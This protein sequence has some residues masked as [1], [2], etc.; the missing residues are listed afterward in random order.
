MSSKLFLKCYGVSLA[1]C[2]QIGVTFLLIKYN[3]TDGN[4]VQNICF[5]NKATSHIK[6]VLYHCIFAL[7]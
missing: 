6:A 3:C 2:L 5:K 1:L 4:H 7:I